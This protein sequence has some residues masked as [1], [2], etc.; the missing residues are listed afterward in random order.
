M[1]D[2]SSEADNNI[3]VLQTFTLVKFIHKGRRKQVEDID[4]VPTN[5]IEFDKKRGRL[6][7]KFL[8]GPYNEEDNLLIHSLVQGL[9]DPPESWPIYSVEVK[10]RANTYE[11][12]LKK[13][14]RLQ[15]EDSVLTM[16][17]EDSDSEVK[18]KII[19]SII[20]RGSFKKN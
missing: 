16:D 20:N 5:W 18:S 3:E 6:A 11:E 8:A 2:T 13:L 19:S 17:S 15:K 7:T 10:G 1:S 14:N 4:I 9:Q 12:A